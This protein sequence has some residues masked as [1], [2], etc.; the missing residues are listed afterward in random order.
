MSIHMYMH[1]SIDM[2][3]HMSTHMSKYMLIHMSTH[4][5][6]HVCTHMS[7]HSLA[8]GESI[9]YPLTH[10]VFSIHHINAYHDIR[11]NSIVLDFFVFD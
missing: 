5:S 3:I 9:L 4:M 2:P 8:T 1:M 11:T 6:T 10:H 7:A